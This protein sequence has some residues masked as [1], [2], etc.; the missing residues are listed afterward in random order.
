MKM[1]KILVSL[2]PFTSLEYSFMCEYVFVNDHGNFCKSFNVFGYA[3][4]CSCSLFDSWVVFCMRAVLPLL[5][6]SHNTIHF[7]MII[8]I[9]KSS[10]HIYYFSIDCVFAYLLLSSNFVVVVATFSVVICA[11]RC[12]I[13]RNKITNEQNVI[14]SYHIT[15]KVQSQEGNKQE[16]NERKKKKKKKNIA[17]AH[18]A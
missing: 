10:M 2:F 3:S 17:T 13:F 11:G 9:F 7:Q 8:S 16:W 1:W 15:S 14:R 12:T 6:C 18:D 4:A 5:F